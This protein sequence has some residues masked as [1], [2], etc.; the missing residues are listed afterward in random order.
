MSD[1]SKAL[2]EAIKRAGVRNDY[3]A[4]QIGVTSGN[5]VSQW[6]R[7]RRPIPAHVAPKLAALLSVPPEA[8]SA[9]YARLLDAGMPPEPQETLIPSGHVRIPSLAEF[10]RTGAMDDCYLLDVL[11]RRKLGTTPL[12]HARWTLQP[13]ATMAPL[14]ERD[15]VLLV[16][17]RATQRADVMDGSIYAFTIW[18]RADARRILVRRDHWVLAGQSPEVDRITVYESDLE[19]VRLFGMVVGWL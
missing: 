1:Y 12:E 8:I 19:Q 13:N 9:A 15:D 10:G 16:D 5:Q 6:R 11:A 3:I 2:T 17:A 7:G 18:G 4:Q 14:I